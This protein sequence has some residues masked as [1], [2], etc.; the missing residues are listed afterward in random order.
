MSHELNEQWEEYIKDELYAHPNEFLEEYLEY[1]PVQSEVIGT[2]RWGNIVEDIYQVPDN[3]LIGVT[4][5]DVSGDGDI[6]AGGMMAD[7]YTVTAEEV[8]VIKYVKV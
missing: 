1:T 8:T 7:F 4:Y 3:S 5:H 2:W 6:D